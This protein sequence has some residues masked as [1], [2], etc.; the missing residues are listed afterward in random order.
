[1]GF[2]MTEVA[3]VFPGQASQRTGMGGDL[4]HDY[5]AAREVFDKA[6]ESLGYSISRICFDGL[7]EELRSTINAQPALLITSYACLQAVGDGSVGG[8]P[9]PKMVA[10]HSLGEYTALV[11]AGVIDFSTAVYL[12]RERG[13][14]MHEAGIMQPGG[15]VAI[16]GFDQEPMTRVCA[17][18]GTWLANINSPKQ[19]IISGAREN[20]ERAAELARERGARRTI[21]LAVSGA[22]HT[23]LMQ[24]ARDGMSE[25]LS[26]LSFQDPVI[27]VVANT[28]AMPMTTAEQVK[29]ELLDQ[30]CN[31]VKWQSSVE[32]MIASG[33]STFIEIGPGEVL[34]GLIKRINSDVST[35]NI[36]DSE[37]VNKY[38]SR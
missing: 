1:M 34:S 23:P 3:Y 30:L 6:D 38:T 29:T 7:E 20:L 16:I 9:E 11:A 35:I 26:G 25:I 27:P 22:F 8:L 12:A 32:Y 19:L 33:I 2:R 31:G 14:L 37:S 17:E 36:S 15:M 24:H 13:R 10:G 18:T 28:T 4:Y 5:T 21:P